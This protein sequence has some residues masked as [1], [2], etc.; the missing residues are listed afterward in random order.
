MRYTVV[1]KTKLS[2]FNNNHTYWK[3]LGCVRYKCSSMT[4]FAVK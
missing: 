4:M 3:H 2:T 1:N